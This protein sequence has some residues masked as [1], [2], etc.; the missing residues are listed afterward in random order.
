MQVM[1]FYTAI[2][3]VFVYAIRLLLPAKTQKWLSPLKC[4]L[5]ALV[6][7]AVLL[8]DSV[9]VIS[10]FIPIALLV[11]GILHLLEK[12]FHIH[13][14]VPSRASFVILCF[15]LATLSTGFVYLT[16]QLAA[17]QSHTGPYYAEAVSESLIPLPLW[18]VLNYSAYFRCDVFRPLIFAALTTATLVI[19]TIDFLRSDCSRA[20]HFAATILLGIYCIVVA[21]APFVDSG[22]LLL[23]ENRNA[24]IRTTGVLENVQLDMSTLHNYHS[25]YGNDMGHIVTING[26]AYRSLWDL[27]GYESGYQVEFTY[28]PKSRILLYI[29]GPGELSAEEE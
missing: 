29:G 2:T 28:L 5:F 7:L 18:Q 22:Y 3:I 14:P 19:L 8:E 21:L 6:L 16:Y 11:F 27:F 17:S 15:S 20:K 13:I 1:L 10:G 12:H 9:L 26:E 4:A 23:Q 24:A 25:L